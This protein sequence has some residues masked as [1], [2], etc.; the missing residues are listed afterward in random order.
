[1]R[2]KFPWK[3]FCQLSAKM[4]EEAIGFYLDGARFTQKINPFDQAR[5][6]RAMA[7]IK[8]GQVFYF[9][10]TGTGVQ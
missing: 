9:S 3:V 6:P 5:T 10:F 8:P 7:W 4:L 2:L 1:M